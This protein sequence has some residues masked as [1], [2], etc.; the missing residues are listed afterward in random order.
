VNPTRGRQSSGNPSS[1]PSPATHLA[2]A[3]ALVDEHWPTFTRKISTR[4]DQ[5]LLLAD[6]TASSSAGWWF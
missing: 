2:N 3:G 1:R 5:L 6:D 4:V